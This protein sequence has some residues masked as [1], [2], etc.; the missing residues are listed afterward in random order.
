MHGTQWHSKLQPQWLIE[1]RWHGTVTRAKQTGNGVHKAM[2]LIYIY[3]YIYMCTY[4]YWV[5]GWTFGWPGVPLGAIGGPFGRSLLT[6]GGLS[7]APVD[8]LARSINVRQ[9]YTAGPAPPGESLGGPGR[10]GGLLGVS[11]VAPGASSGGSLVAPGEPA[12]AP[13][14]SLA[15][16]VSAR[17]TYRTGTGSSGSPRVLG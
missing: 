14:A 9:T 5:A 1:S 17:Q 7:D 10:S 12:G 4:I 11:F 6:R 2:S 8:S 13:F 15:T 16:S 3:I